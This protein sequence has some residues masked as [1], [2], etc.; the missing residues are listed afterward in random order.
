MYILPVRFRYRFLPKMIRKEPQM[1]QR[2]TK[3]HAEE[4]INGNLLTYSSNYEFTSPWSW[5]LRNRTSNNRMVSG[6]VEEYNHS[7]VTCIMQ[8]Y[9]I[10]FWTE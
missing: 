4:K 10:T 3:L 2:A 7:K 5:H 6:Y 8:S 9:E 1:K